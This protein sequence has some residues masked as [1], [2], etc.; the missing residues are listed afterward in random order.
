MCTNGGSIGFCKFYSDFLPPFRS[1][2]LVNCTSLDSL[3][4]VVYFHNGLKVICA[5][6]K[7]LERDKCG[8][9]GG[10]YVY[11]NRPVVRS[12]YV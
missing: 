6:G 11:L 8:K 2:T 12:A 4:C 9:V 7:H 10:S 3:R 1:Q 5:T